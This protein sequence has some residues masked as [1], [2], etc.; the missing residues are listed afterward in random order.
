MNI[1]AFDWI[2]LAVLLLSMALGAWR[3]LVHEVLAVLGWVAAF[4][5]AQLY[6]T[7]VGQLLPLQ[8]AGA[9]VRYA[10]GFAAVFISTVIA[11]SILTWL[12]KQMIEGVGLRPID[13]TLGA[14]FGV[15]RGLLILLA[16]ATVVLMTPLKRG[17]WW[18]QSASAGPLSSMLKGI[19][20]V[21][22]AEFGQ[23]IQAAA[24]VAPAKGF[25][26]CVES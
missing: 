2:V 20:P 13:R 24:K 5:L 10:A 3:G 21:L 16:V 6:A 12:I 22:P 4:I 7:T 26:I 18:Q 19:K 11:C 23:Y 25:V 8:G 14:A 9:P 15:L 17:D 1:T